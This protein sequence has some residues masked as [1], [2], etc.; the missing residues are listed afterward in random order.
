M[1]QHLNVNH[2]FE[3]DQKL[4]KTQKV[5]NVFLTLLIFKFQP[6]QKE[7]YLVDHK[8]NMIRNPPTNS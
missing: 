3:S 2:V 6:L 4:E 5:N 7:T 8:R 1:R